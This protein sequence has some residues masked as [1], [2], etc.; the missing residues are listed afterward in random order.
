[1]KVLAFNG[2][3]IKTWNTALNKMAAYV[4]IVKGAKI[5]VGVFF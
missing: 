1:M 4:S 5:P 2:S 3:P